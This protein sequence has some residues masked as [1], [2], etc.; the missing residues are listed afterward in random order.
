MIERIGVVGGGPAGII[1]AGYAGAN[2]KDVVLIEKNNKLGKKLY[3]TG[4]GRCNITNG[5]SIENFFDNIVNNSSFLYSS[6]YSFTNE[7]IISLL[8]DYGLETKIERGNRVFPISDKSSDVIKALEKF[9]IDKNV[10]IILNT[11]VIDIHYENNKFIVEVEKGVRMEFDKII[12]ATGGISYPAT[13]STGDGYKF[14]K[15]FGHKV[16]KLNP[17]LVPMEIENEWI[18]GL[19]G[20]SLKNVELIS[21]RGEKEI[22][23]EFGEM[24]FTHYGISG[25]IVLTTSSFINKYN[26]EGI[27]FSLDLKP[28]LSRE[29]LDKRILRD[30]ELY[31]NKQIS[32][33]LFDLLPQKII[34]VIIKES[35][36]N[37]KTIINQITKAERNRLVD[38]IKGLNLKYKG[39]RPIK[40]AVVTSGGILIDEIEPSTM[41][42]KLIPGLFFAGE[43]IDVDGLTGGFNLQIAYST[44]YLSGNNV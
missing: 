26:T 7:D 37:E 22:Y 21:Y 12:L 8:K 10:N 5:V 41:E 4:K 31:K 42:S 1:A 9:L 13:G 20:L 33:G 30:F 24:L 17:A 40:E 15:K 25:P 43:I 19:Q 14:A 2:G 34:P 11:N 27:R 6:L 39:L 44:G 36:I 3:I 38:N 35:F 16:Q 32:N 23:R 28:S 29:K 18:R